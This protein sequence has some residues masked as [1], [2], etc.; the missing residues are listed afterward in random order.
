[1]TFARMMLIVSMMCLLTGCAT[2]V[3]YDYDGA[4]DFSKLKTFQWTSISA[5]SDVDESV[6]DFVQKEINKSLFEK[7]F[8]LASETPGFLVS[9][10]I[11][12]DVKT[13]DSDL[14][15][16]LTSDQVEDVQYLEGSL[17]L[18]FS[19]STSGAPIWWGA[20]QT[21]LD[22][23]YPKEKKKQIVIQAVAKILNKFPPES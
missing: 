21:R 15:L 10:H 8:T 9:A 2:T 5:F 3:K 23:D 1:M 17:I 12:K 4:V 13:K 7:G 18:V 16:N 19:N 22:K 14:K 20:V 11:R 6:K